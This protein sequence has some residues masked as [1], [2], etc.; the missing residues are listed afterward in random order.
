MLHIY[1]TISYQSNFVPIKSWSAAFGMETWVKY[2]KTYKWAEFQAESIDLE[3]SA[4]TKN[5]TTSLN[6]VFMRERHNHFA[7]IQRKCVWMTRIPIKLTIQLKLELHSAA[8]TLN[9]DC[10]STT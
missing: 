9:N 5:L 8:K 7:P 1:H 10:T 2:I 4:A 3:A 6:D